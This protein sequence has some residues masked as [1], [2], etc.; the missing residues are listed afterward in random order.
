MTVLRLRSRRAI[1]LADRLLR[2]RF[3]ASPAR[4]SPRSRAPG[5]SCSATRR[6]TAWTHDVPL[7]IAGGERAITWRCSTSQRTKRGW[8]GR[9]RH[10]RAT[11][12]RSWPRWRSRR[13]TR[14]SAIRRLFVAT[15]QAVSG[16]GYPGVPSLDILGNVIPYI[17]DEEPKIETRDAE[18]ARHARRRRAS[19]RADIAISAHANR[20]PVEHGHTVCMSI[21]LR[22]TRASAGRGARGAARVARRTSRARAAERAGARARRRATSPIARSRAA[23]S[24]PGSGMTVD[25]RARARRI[26]CST[27]SSWRWGTT[28]SAAPPA[29]SVLNAEL[30]VATGRLGRRVIVVKFG[31]TSVGDAEAIARTADDRARH[32]A[33]AQPIVVVS[34]LGG[35]TN[36][37]LAI[38]EQAAEG[39]AHRR[40]ARGRGAARPAPARRRRRCSATA[41]E[42]GRDLRPS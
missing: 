41:P 30:L 9:H 19:S 23:T 33:T 6:T 32:G 22:A 39:P 2:A 29:R 12:R 35:T 17:S 14:R 37:L 15:M 16:A 10:Q 5:D 26:R 28:R 18:D 25:R 1:T 13:C 3:V 24:T 7:V 11:A 21:E 38:A 36:A 40:A 27:C 31:G 4:S 42:R 20:V 8:S 34:A